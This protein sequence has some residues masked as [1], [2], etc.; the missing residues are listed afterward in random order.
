MHSDALLR[1]RPLCIPA[2]LL[3]G[4]QRELLLVYSLVRFRDFFKG[5]RQKTPLRHL[6]KIY[7]LPG[8]TLTGF[9]KI[10]HAPF[11]RPKPFP[12]FPPPPRGRRRRKCH[13]KCLFSSGECRQRAEKRAQF[14]NCRFTPPEKYDTVIQ[15]MICAPH[16][17]GFRGN[18]LPYF[19]SLRPSPSGNTVKGGTQHDPQRRK[20]LR[21]RGKPYS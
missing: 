18:A 9:T 3:R 8:R 19:T 11:R 21:N 17:P 2:T 6:R 16:S 15:H 13:R 14:A 1:K 4:Q 5:F 10:S 12:L 7:N 20:D